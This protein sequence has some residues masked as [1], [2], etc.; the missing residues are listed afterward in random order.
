MT[1]LNGTVNI[2]FSILKLFKGG[3]SRK[4]DPFTALFQVSEDFHR[5]FLLECRDY[6]KGISDLQDGILS[7]RVRNAL[8]DTLNAAEGV[9]QLC[10]EKPGT[11]SSIRDLPSTLRRI[12]EAMKSFTELA[13]PVDPQDSTRNKE[14]CALLSGLTHHLRTT[15]EEMM[16]GTEINFSALT[17]VLERSLNRGAQ[18]QAA[19][20]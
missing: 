4:E 15:R 19:Q 7:R 10:G 8:A 1:P 9:V 14:M 12:H 16:S 20:Q 3:Q 6:L 17:A 18:P 5:Q 11:I 2:M 13:T